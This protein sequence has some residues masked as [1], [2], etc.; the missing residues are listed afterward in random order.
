MMLMAVVMV[1]GGNDGVNENHN[2]IPSRF[3]LFREKIKSKTNKQNSLHSDMQLFRF[4]S[5]LFLRVLSLK[6]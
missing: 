3:L 4:W 1:Y 6:F 2:R 5:K